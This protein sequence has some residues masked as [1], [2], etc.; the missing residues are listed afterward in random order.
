MYPSKATGLADR[1]LQFG[2]EINCKFHP[3]KP[4]RDPHQ[5][6]YSF[7]NETNISFN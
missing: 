4:K 6:K 2:Q 5:H 7:S 3:I 1:G